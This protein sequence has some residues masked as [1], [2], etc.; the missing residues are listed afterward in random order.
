M[1]I[2]QSPCGDASM[3]ALA[4]LQTTESFELFEAGKKRKRTTVE[5][6]P[7]LIENIYKNKKRLK[8]SEINE[9]E[10]FQRGRFGFNQ[11]GILR[12]KPGRLDSEPT[13]CMSCSDKLARWNVLGLQ[14]ALLS[15]FYDPIYLSSIIV[16]DMFDKDALE[17]ALFKRI[18][19]IKGLPVPYRLNKPAIFSTEIQYEASKLNLES[20]GKYKAVIP[21]GT[22]I[23]WVIG[24]PKSEVFV[25]GSKQGAPKNKP[26]N[27]KTRPSICKRGL[28][29][30]LSEIENDIPNISYLN[31]KMN[32]S[33]EYQKAKYCLLDQVFDTWVQKPSE[34]DDFT[35]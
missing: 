9:K 16:G 24:M 34:Y 30:K 23:S 35:I 14:S 29:Q 11:L 25:N 6:Y 31:W 12:T 27:S 2:S 3:N 21:C 18:K 1:Y 5:D 7:F 22:A 10:Q 20:T 28:Y 33:G 19:D 26:L 8:T 13:L 32:H 4:S 15:K 17:R